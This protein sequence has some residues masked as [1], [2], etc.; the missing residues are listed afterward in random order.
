MVTYEYWRQEWLKKPVLNGEK[1]V[2]Q[3]VGPANISFFITVV[4][5]E[6]DCCT[7]ALKNIFEQYHGRLSQSLGWVFKDIGLIVVSQR[8]N[9]MSVDTIT[10]NALSAGAK[11]IHFD[12]SDWISIYCPAHQLEQV[13]D[14]LLLEDMVL[15]RA[16]IVPVP[17]DLFP[18]YAQADGL[19]LVALMNQLVQL[20]YV[21]DIAADF[22]LEEKWLDQDNR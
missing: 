11:D 16:E 7:E 5:P 3:G 18:I 4:S 10:L 14:I 21:Y 15:Y 17:K 19:A 12:D 9:Q 1:K 20:P 2:I 13:K 6:V 8:M 22:Q